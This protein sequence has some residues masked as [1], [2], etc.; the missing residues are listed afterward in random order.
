M[1]GWSQLLALSAAVLTTLAQAQTHDANGA[2][3]PATQKPDLSPNAPIRWSAPLETKSPDSQTA[4]DAES[5]ARPGHTT[6]APEKFTELGSARWV[7]P[8]LGTERTETPRG[9]PKSRLEFERR[10]APTRD[11]DNPFQQTVNQWFYRTNDA[12]FTWYGGFQE[13]QRDFDNTVSQAVF[14]KSSEP[15]VN[16]SFFGQPRFK[17]KVD[18]SGA[19]IRL[20]VPFGR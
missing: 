10:F 6:T 14:G 7:V 20:D 4:T 18:P 13:W 11:Y 8:L 16:D 19:T 12:I 9:F 15:S 1:K 3:K 2:T 17:S 5:P